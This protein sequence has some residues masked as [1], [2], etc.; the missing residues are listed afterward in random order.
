M[1]IQRF[2]PA[3]H[4]R[5]QT[6]AGAGEGPAVALGKC[7]QICLAFFQRTLM[8]ILAAIALETTVAQ[9]E[10]PLPTVGVSLKT[11]GVSPGYT[12]ISPISSN[13]VFLLDNDGMVAHVW[14]TDRHPGQMAYLLE[15]GSLLRAGKADEFYQ[16][17]STT[18]SGG[19][20]QKYDWDG[21]LLWDY[22]TSSAYR[23]S[24]HDIEPL[25][26][27]NVLCIVWESYLRE[28][29]EQAGRNPDRLNS[30]VLWFEAIFELKPNGLNGAD[31][32][33]KWS[34][35]DHLVQDWDQS[36]SNYGNPAEHPELVDINFTLRP[37][38]DWVHLNSIDYNPELDQIMVCSRSLN[39][40]WIID[41]STT[42]EE[43]KGH[44]GGKYKRGG[45]LLYRWGNPLAYRRGQTKDR[46]LFSPHDAH[47]I[48]QGLPGAGHVLI[49]NNGV[50]DTDQNYSSADEIVLPLLPD[51]TYQIEEEKPF[52]PT[53]LTWTFE[54]PRNFFSPR[55]SGTQRL[56]NGNTLICSGTQHTLLE[57]TAAAEIVWMYHNPPR[58]R[59][60]KSMS[61]RGTGK[62][63]RPSIADLPKEKLDSLRIDRAVQL[64]NGGT[65]FRAT[66]HLPEYPAFQGRIFK[67]RDRGKDMRDTPTNE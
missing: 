53:E 52:G 38:A 49:F 24:H 57:V 26:N 47:W 67:V 45:D 66:K 27:G 56:P 62:P 6:V 17:P 23:M 28:V 36:K 42:T 20:I 43:A 12:L 10:A 7:V 15:D 19:R 5:N 64:E 32:V 11:E 1:L 50:A 58:F 65:M 59:E 16:F 30:E 13:S 41:H 4:G 9:E 29:A 33:W 35:L 25:P 60:P 63:A 3:R 22:S 31:V 54:D 2:S 34:L 51:G 48:P 18:G 8:V 44:V 61:Q 55:I 37:T 40:F 21:N 14:K 39:E 46:M